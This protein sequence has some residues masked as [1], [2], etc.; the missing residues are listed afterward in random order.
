MQASTI[1]VYNG[2]INYSWNCN[3]DDEAINQ[4]CDGWWRAQLWLVGASAE[5]VVTAEDVKHKSR[6]WTFEG[7]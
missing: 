6:C 2:I 3:G 5:T 7:V 4:S 1:V